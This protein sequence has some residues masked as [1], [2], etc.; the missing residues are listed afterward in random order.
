MSE[1][2][3]HESHGS[4]TISG[5]AGGPRM[6]QASAEKESAVSLVFHLCKLGNTDLFMFISCQIIKL[7]EQGSLTF[8]GEAGVSKRVSVGREFSFPCSCLKPFDL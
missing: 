4:H 8:G 3:L 2:N 7:K 5:M 6:K 1:N